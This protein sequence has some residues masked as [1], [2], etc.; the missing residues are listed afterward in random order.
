MKVLVVEDSPAVQEFLIHV[1]SSDPEI[2][3]IGSARDG[4]EALEA[5]KRQRPDIV[6]MDIHMPKMNGLEATRRIMETVPTPIVIVSGTSKIHGVEPTFHAIEAGALA[7]VQRPKGLGHPAYEATAKDFVE[8]VKLMSEVKVVRRWARLRS[9]KAPAVPSL[10][11]SDP[12]PA[13]IRLV[14]IGASTGGPLVIQTILSRLPKNFSVPIVIVQHMSPGFIEGFAEWLGHS[15][16]FPVRVAAHGEA[17]LPGHAYIAPDG[18][19]MS[20][21]RNAR[22]G[23]RK[24]ELENGL[25]PSV[26]YLFRSV[27]K[28][29]EQKAIGVLLTG[30]G[31]DGAAEL[32]LMKEQGAITLVQDKE[33]SVVHGMPGEAILLEAS[34]YVFPPEGIATALASLVKAGSSL[35]EARK[36]RL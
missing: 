17:L 33:S 3:V 36:G 24:D 5:V 21:E 19:Q 1:L 22:I 15:S 12:L 25:C 28:I 20:V 9:D 10:Q 11:T 32:K 2:Q 31:K 8:T 23:L 35:A 7:F 26:S 30:M 14:A 13:E 4:E 29:Y 6:T 16:G 18:F 34:T 27:A